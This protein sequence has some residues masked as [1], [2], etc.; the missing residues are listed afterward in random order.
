MKKAIIEVS[1]KQFFLQDDGSCLMSFKDDIHGANRVDVI[2]GTGEL[3]KRFSYFF[4]K[5]LEEHG[6]NTHLQP[7]NALNERG[8]LVKKLHPVKIEILVRNIARGHWVDSHKVPLFSPGEVFSEPIVEF[9]V[10]IKE[11]LPDGRILDDPRANTDIL[12]ALHRG[13]KDKKL[14]GNMLRS[15]EEGER[16][17]H[18]ALQINTLYKDFLEENNWILEDFKFE[19]GVENPKEDHPLFILIDEISPDCS[20]I[21][22]HEGNSLTK[23]LFRERKSELKIYE[24]YKMLSDAIESKVK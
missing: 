16:L 5:Y 11:E 9:C 14:K 23:D 17:R 20:R 10:K 4:Y 21:R 6:I 12:A 8:I 19:V 22:D 2:S 1:S 15:R 7:D 3:R 13:A 24:G 18:I